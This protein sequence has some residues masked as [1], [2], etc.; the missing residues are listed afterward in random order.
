MKPMPMRVFVC[1]HC[2]KQRRT[3]C[4]KVCRLDRDDPNTLCFE[5]VDDEA[6][7]DA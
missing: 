1:Q 4:S 7:N 5:V 6:M 3:P 2:W